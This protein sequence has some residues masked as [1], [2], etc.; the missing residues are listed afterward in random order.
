MDPYSHRCRITIAS[1]HRP[2]LQRDAFQQLQTYI[3]RTSHSSNVDARHQHCHSLGFARWIAE[4]AEYTSPPQHLPPPLPVPGHN[5]T[6][7]FPDWAWDKW[8]SIY[9][10]SSG[11]GG[12]PQARCLAVHL[13]TDIYLA[14]WRPASRTITAIHITPNIA[15]QP[16][17][18]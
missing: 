17:N 1:T 14:H 12:I 11:W 5:S 10:T 8:N 4:P 9:S 16:T 3:Y 18:C 13:N 7:A 2:L 15:H 6:P